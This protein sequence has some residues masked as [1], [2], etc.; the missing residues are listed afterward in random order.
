MK[1]HLGIIYKYVNDFIYYNFNIHLQFIKFNSNFISLIIFYAMHIINA[2]DL[3]ILSISG[4]METVTHFI[5]FTDKTKE[6]EST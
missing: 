6:Q 5:R 3:C 1:K 4:I 2:F